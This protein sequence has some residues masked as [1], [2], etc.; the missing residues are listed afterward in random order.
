VEFGVDSL[1]RVIRTAMVNAA[2]A[3]GRV[4]HRVSFKGASPTSLARAERHARPALAQV[5]DR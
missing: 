1:L 4:P 5:S 3:H 2:E